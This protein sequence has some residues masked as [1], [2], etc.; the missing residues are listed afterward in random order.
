MTD[1]EAEDDDV[2]TTDESYRW[3]YLST[4]VVSTVVVGYT[5]LVLGQAYG[6]TRPVTGGTWATYSLAF[7]AAVIYSL[8]KDI[9]KDA[10]ELRGT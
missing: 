1:D 3:R 6:L 8:G 9:V 7:L 10:R 4:I 5:A 2:G